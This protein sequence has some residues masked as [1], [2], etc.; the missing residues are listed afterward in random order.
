M[1]E[2]DELD[3]ANM[4]KENFQ[5]KLAIYCRAI[6]LIENRNPM[7][8]HNEQ[9]I[10]NLSTFIKRNKKLLHLNLDSTQLSEYMLFNLCKC[11]TRAQ[12]LLS[13]HA[14]GNPGI[15]VE[16]KEM[17]WRRIRAKDP[18]EPIINI[19]ME[20]ETKKDW[21]KTIGGQKREQMLKESLE[22]RAMAK[23]A[24]DKGGLTEVAATHH[25]TKLI[26]TRYL[27]HRMDIPGSG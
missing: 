17:L 15:S 18:H 1:S 13:L 9:I 27:G 16:L 26:F 11:L 24:L 22:V 21:K 14:S 10:T 2:L 25:D 8:K 5:E 12:S 4:T 19:Q 20:K 6:E 3:I 23:R 7:K